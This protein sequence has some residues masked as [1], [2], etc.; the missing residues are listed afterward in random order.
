M[1]R[2]IN[3]LSNNIFGPK[4]SKSDLKKKR[5]FLNNGLQEHHQQY[6]TLFFYLSA[7]KGNKSVYRDKS[8]KNKGGHCKRKRKVIERKKKIL[9]VS[10]YH[11][12]IKR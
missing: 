6:N 10:D 2:Q 1:S 4:N 7:K 11:Y 12:M 3:I 5:D 9:E 8:N